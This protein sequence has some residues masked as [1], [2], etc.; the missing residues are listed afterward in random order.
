[1]SDRFKFAM[2]NDAALDRR[3]FIGRTLLAASCTVL[4][5]AADSAPDNAKV[6][7]AVITRAGGAHVEMYFHALAQAEEVGSVVLADPD[8]TFETNARG[9]L[10]AKFAKVY[11]DYH[12]LIANEKPVMAL[13]SMEAK[14]APAAIDAALDAGCHVMAEKP[15]CTNAEDFAKLAAKANEKKLHLMLALC[16]RV[17]PEVLEAKRLVASGEIGKVYGI[18]M[19]L[20]QDQTRLTSAAFHK[21]CLADKARAG[22]GHLTSPGIHWLDL[23]MFITRPR[24]DQVVGFAGNDG[25][26][27]SSRSISVGRCVVGSLWTRSTSSRPSVGIPRAW[28]KPST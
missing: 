25:G 20:V 11:A 27:L 19:H 6:T 24:T 15:A 10:G 17:N 22:G 9:T 1:M 16:N 28:Q 13:I 5:G 2:A 4:A 7:V 26:S 12:E 14:L 23:A 21:S 18:E 3:V 8:G